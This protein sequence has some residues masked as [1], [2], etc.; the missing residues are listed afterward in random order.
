MKQLSFGASSHI[1]ILT[2]KKVYE[3]LVLLK[4]RIS[5]QD[6]NLMPALNAKIKR[7]ILPKKV[8]TY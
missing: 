3:T 8:H 4:T 2:T 1:L 5:K 6:A 7:R